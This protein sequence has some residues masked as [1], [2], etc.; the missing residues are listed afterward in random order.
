MNDVFI[1]AHL[2]RY[3]DSSFMGLTVQT[4]KGPLIQEYLLQALNQLDFVESL[5]RRVYAVRLDLYLP[6]WALAADCPYLQ[7]VNDRSL[8]EKFIASLEGRI[9]TDCRNRARAGHRVSPTR[10]HWIRAYEIGHEQGNPHFHLMLL[11]NGDTYGALGSFDDT[12][13]NLMGRIQA[14]WAS[15]LALPSATDEV[16]Q[17]GLVNVSGQYRFNPNDLDAKDRCFEALS[18]L[19]KA[20]TKPFLGKVHPF[21]CAPHKYP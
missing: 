9:N 6:S 5:Y 20:W 17:M 8:I 15:A 4:K 18:Y 12:S 13:N 7:E 11:V 19:C 1:P 3:T 14:A 2:T 16:R 21:R 10:V